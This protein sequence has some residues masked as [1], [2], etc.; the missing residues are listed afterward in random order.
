MKKEEGRQGAR[1]KGRRNIIHANR[2]RRDQKT[3]LTTKDA[4]QADC[5]NYGAR[6]YQ[7][8]HEQDNDDEEGGRRKEEGGRR[9]EERRTRKEY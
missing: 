5:E 6:C 7:Y 8:E 9:K 4:T 3:D 2:K 1:Q